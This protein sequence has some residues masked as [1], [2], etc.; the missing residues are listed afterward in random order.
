MSRKFLNLAVLSVLAVGLLTA[1]NCGA[2]D[3]N[4]RHSL[5]GNSADSNGSAALQPRNVNPQNEYIHNTGS[6]SSGP[7]S[8][9][10]AKNGRRYNK[11]AVSR[12]NV[13][14]DNEEEVGYEDENSSTQKRNAKKSGVKAEEAR[15]ISDKNLENREDDMNLM[16]AILK[17]VCKYTTISNDV[18]G[19]IS[20]NYGKFLYNINDAMERGSFSDKR[21]SLKSIKPS[22]P[23]Q[24]GGKESSKTINEDMACIV[25][26]FNLDPRQWSSD[27]SCSVDAPKR[28]L[29][30]AI[31]ACKKYLG[32]NSDEEKEFKRL[33]DEI[34]K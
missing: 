16:K 17:L 4:H 12:E 10:Y 11:G 24:E 34:T 23:I 15:S 21:I 13:E 25:K 6:Q 19:S 26:G 2:V 18:K 33:L 9:D 5:E 14:S 32:P 30:N 27:V 3:V 1:A 8:Q 29:K 7:S 22:D 31:E 20:V 28:S